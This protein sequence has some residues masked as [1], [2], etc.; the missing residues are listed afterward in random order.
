M[1][2]ELVVG[3]FLGGKF[4]PERL[5]QDCLAK[6]QGMAIEVRAERRLDHRQVVLPLRR[7][8]GVAASCSTMV[9][10]ALICGASLPR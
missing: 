1:P 5:T 8:H 3:Q 4:K 6:R 2:A 10:M 9:Q 7:A